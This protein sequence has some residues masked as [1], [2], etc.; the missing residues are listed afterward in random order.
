MYVRVFKSRQSNRAY[1]LSYVPNLNTADG[2]KYYLTSDIPY[3]HQSIEINE[4]ELFNVLNKLFKDTLN[5]KDGGK[6]RSKKD[7]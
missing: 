1:T 2:G 5:E 3:E 4:C 7:D 6:E